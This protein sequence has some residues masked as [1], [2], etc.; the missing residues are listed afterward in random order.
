[1][2]DPITILFSL[3]V[4]VLCGLIFGSLPA[5][6]L[7]GSNRLGQ[8][9][10]SGNSASRR[11][12]LLGE[13][14]VVVQLG[15][16]LAMLVSAGLMVR[17]VMGLRNQPLGFSPESVLSVD[18]TLHHSRYSERQERMVFIEQLESELS[19]LPGVTAVGGTQFFFLTDGTYHNVISGI[20]GSREQRMPELE[21]AAAFVTRGYF[22]ALGVRFEEGR[23]FEK[24]SG[25]GNE[26]VVVTRWLA[27]ALSEE[28]GLAGHEIE[29]EGRWWRVVG[30]ASD[31]LM[32]GAGDEPAPALFLPLELAMLSPGNVTILVRSSAE[33][34][35]LAKGIRQRI[36]EIDP[37]Q[38]V[39]RIV[40]VEEEVRR[41]SATESFGMRLL[42]AFAVLAILVAA[43]GIHGLLGYAVAVRRRDFGIRMAV[44]ATPGRVHR[45][46]ARRA[47]VLGL[48]GMAVG[49]VLA[50]LAGQ[51]LS[52]LLYG[53]EPWDPITWALALL[54]ALVVAAACSWVPGRRAARV[55]PAVILREE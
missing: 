3:S 12:R 8:G 10:L 32:P 45:E 52:T 38:A 5:F 48:C 41:R 36:D 20:R 44:G 29:F 18:L 31:L 39:G 24:P 53:V 4:A 11:Y 46:I 28:G 43:I 1:G 19:S 42:A 23:A 50:T 14:V 2:V 15:L 16:S 34:Y 49:A 26:E 22:D 13:L 9:I 51:A 7:L 25:Y 6:C 37:F 21:V 55:D 27:R 33:T 54:T 47:L 35:G 30:I 40:S 17:S